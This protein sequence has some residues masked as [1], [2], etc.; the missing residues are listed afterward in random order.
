MLAVSFISIL[1]LLA[2]PF[3]FWGSQA[4]YVSEPPDTARVAFEMRLPRSLAADSGGLTPDGLAMALLDAGE[5]VYRG[6]GARSVWGLMWAIRGSEAIDGRPIG[7]ARD[8]APGTHALSALTSPEQLAGILQ[9]IGQGLSDTF[10]VEGET[11]GSATVT[12]PD[13]GSLLTGAQVEQG[14]A[15]VSPPVSFVE[16]LGLAPTQAALVFVAAPARVDQIALFDYA[17]AILVLELP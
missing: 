12:A 6:D 11:F 5:V 3:G 4:A 9:G 14:L 16:R 8:L 7:P 1:P 17:P 13:S 10:I 2:S 15:R